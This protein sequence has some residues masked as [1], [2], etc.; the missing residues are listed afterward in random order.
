M[1][2]FP[3]GCMKTDQ[4]SSV[5]FCIKDSLS[6]STRHCPGYC[7]DTIVWG[8]LTFL[9]ILWAE[10][11]TA[12]VQ[13][14]YPTMLVKWRVLEDGKHVSLWN[15]RQASLL[16]IIKDLASFKLGFLSCRA[17]NC[18]CPCPLAL[19]TLPYGIWVLR[20]APENP[21]SWI[22]I[23]LLVIKS[24]IYGLG[25]SYLLPESMKLSG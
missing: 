5:C 6:S 16:P 10:T 24:F 15:K 22:L 21:V 25:I 1:K 14:N 11:V 9:H 17:T 4:F 7:W 20:K 3:S 13:D 23:L 8:S 18:K 12:A 2:V 19:C